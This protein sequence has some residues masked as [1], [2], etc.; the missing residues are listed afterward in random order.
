MARQEYGEGCG[1]E[2]H[3]HLP[4]RVPLGMVLHGQER[5]LGGADAVST[6]GDGALHGKS[7]P[8]ATLSNAESPEIWIR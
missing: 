3:A 6:S 2:A 1:E 7:F 5:C 8:E 4:E